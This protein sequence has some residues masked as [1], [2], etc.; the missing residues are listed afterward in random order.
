MR[1]NWPWPFYLIEKYIRLQFFLLNA[2]HK[3]AKIF[4]T[5]ETIL[6]QSREDAEFFNMLYIS[7]VEV[8][9]LFGLPKVGPNSKLFKIIMESTTFYL[10]KHL[11]YGVST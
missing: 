3:G 4:Y 8:P 9:S 1:S 2:K 5:G 11:S 7:T 10:A 6:T